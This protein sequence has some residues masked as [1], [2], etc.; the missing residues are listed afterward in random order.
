LPPAT[1]LAGS[2]ANIG[3]AL[4]LNDLP[5]RASPHEPRL[6]KAPIRHHPHQ[7]G[8]TRPAFFVFGNAARPLTEPPIRHI[9]RSQTA[10]RPARGNCKHHPRTPASDQR[11]RPP[12]SAALH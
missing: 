9:V 3:R 2:V 11:S 12:S 7:G 6:P 1:D 5:R 8:P 10:T 4:A